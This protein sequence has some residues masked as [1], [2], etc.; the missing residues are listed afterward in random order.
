M[1]FTKKQKGDNG[2]S[3]SDVFV[4]HFFYKYPMIDCLINSV[5]HFPWSLFYFG[6]I[7]FL[8]LLLFV[9]MLVLLKLYHLGHVECNDYF[10]H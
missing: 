6:H 5:S 10:F 7:F 9:F 4:V 2:A 1:R 8:F 3:I